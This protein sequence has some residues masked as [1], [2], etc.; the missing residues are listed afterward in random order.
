[1]K[2]PLIRA[3]CI[4]VKVA[5]FFGAPDC[6]NDIERTGEYDAQYPYTSPQATVQNV[7]Q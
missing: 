7:F 5:R 1:M 2:R 6:F 3:K 4:M